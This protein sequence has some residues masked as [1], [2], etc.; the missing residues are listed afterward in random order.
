MTFRARAEKHPK[1]LSGEWTLDQVLASFLDTFDSPEDKDGMVTR[2][3]FINY[4]AGVS[5]TVEDDAYFDL[6]MRACWGLPPRGRRR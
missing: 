3:E 4:Y 2:D 1:F 5:S 6:M